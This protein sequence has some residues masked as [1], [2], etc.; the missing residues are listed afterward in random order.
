MK[1][2]YLTYDGLSDPL[3]QSQIMPYLLQLAEKGFSIT[4]VSF[5]KREAIGESHQSIKEKL[6]EKKINWVPLKYT[7]HPPVISTIF[8]ILKLKQECIRLHKENNYRIVHCRSYITAFAGMLMKKKFRLKFIF[9]IRGF[10]ADERVEG[11]LWNQKKIMYRYIYQYFKRKEKIFFHAADK[12][13]TLTYAAKK[14]IVDHFSIAP[15]K[16]QVI[17]CCVDTLLFD[18]SK[19]NLQQQYSLKE[20]LS[21]SKDDFVLSYLGA[22]GT[23]YLL[24]EM[25]DFFRHLIIQYPNATFLFVT[26]HPKEKIM[27]SAIQKNIPAEKIMVVK[28][29]RNDVPGLLALSSVSIFFIKPTYS[30][31]ASSPTKQAELLSMGIPVICNTRIGDTEEII[32]KS[33]AGLLIDQFTNNEYDRA[34]KQIPL[35]LEKDKTKIRDFARHEFSL[36]RGVNFYSEIYLELEK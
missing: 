3:G 1:I 17:P 31:I 30:K 12:I 14:I 18:P 23:W 33:G 25:L 6:D 11:G 4:I 20:K 22:L 5:E 16:L 7:R 8:D 10:Y 28:A 32:T 34:I 13:V 2:L 21:I 15:S 24:D 29:K 35:L 9:D 26:Y 19:T 36:D 27:Q